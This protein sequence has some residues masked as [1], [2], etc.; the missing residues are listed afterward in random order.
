MAKM[1]KDNQNFFDQMAG[2]SIQLPVAVQ[3]ELAAMVQRAYSSQTLGV[4]P[5]QIGSLPINLDP[6]YAQHLPGVN[7][8]GGIEAALQQSVMPQ[9]LGMTQRVVE[10]RGNADASAI[11]SDLYSGSIGAARNYNPDQSTF[12]HFASRQAF[13]AASTSRR[14]EFRG[15]SLDD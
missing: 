4:D 5:S 11:F 12:A 8:M 7:T 15:V 10:N 13:E 9:L 6:R 3:N 2:S 14:S 1:R